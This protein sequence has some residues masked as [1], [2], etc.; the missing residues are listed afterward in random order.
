MNLK[1]NELQRV[2]FL[3]RL[4]KSS[5]PPFCLEKKGLCPF[6]LLLFCGKS[7]LSPFF[8]VKLSSAKQEP[9]YSLS[10]FCPFLFSFCQAK[11]GKNGEGRIIV[12]YNLF[13]FVSRN[14]I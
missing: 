5:P 12:S 8:L 14:F 4:E 6:S 9:Q 3:C 13:L 7:C 2:V 11:C 10:F 1:K